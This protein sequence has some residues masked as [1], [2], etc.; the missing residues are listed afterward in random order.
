MQK[1]ASDARL[2]ER[3]ECVWKQVAFRK[4]PPRTGGVAAGAAVGNIARPITCPYGLLDPGF[5]TARQLLAALLRLGESCHWV[6][7]PHVRK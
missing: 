7:P 3:I 1:A 2:P 5:S 4:R 6:R